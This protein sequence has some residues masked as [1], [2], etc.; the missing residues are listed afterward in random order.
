MLGH[1]EVVICSLLLFKNKEFLDN[2]DPKMGKKRVRAV[3]A[4]KL[5]I[6]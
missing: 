4:Q 5:N 1:Q 6:S 3:V 2:P